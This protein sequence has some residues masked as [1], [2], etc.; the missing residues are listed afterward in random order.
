[1]RIDANE[2]YPR[3]FFFRNVPFF[4]HQAKV[5]RRYSWLDTQ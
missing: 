4:S 3:F 5:I 2:K 1:M